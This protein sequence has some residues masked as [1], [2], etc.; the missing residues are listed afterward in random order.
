INMSNSG[1]AADTAPSIKT[2]VQSGVK[3]A[4]LVM[5]Q[6]FAP[7]IGGVET[8]LSDLVSELAK[9]RP[10]FV[11]TLKPIVTGSAS[12]LRRERRPNC[13]IRRFWW[14][15]GAVNIYRLLEPLPLLLFLYIVPYLFLR[16]FFFMLRH[17]RRISVIN[18]HG[19]NAACAAWPLGF[20]FRKKII[21]QT[22]SIYNFAPGSLFARAAAFIMNR[23]FK[24]LS[25][26][27]VGS[28]EIAAISV[29]AEKVGEFRYW[30]NLANFS[31]HEKAQA[32]RKAGWPAA[33]AV[34]FVG[35][36]LSI[37]GA[38]YAGLLARD[39][40]AL[41][42]YVIGDGPDRGELSEFNC[43]PNFSRLGSIPNEDL[44]DY[45]SAADL[46]I[47]P[48]QY[49]EGFG[50]VI[51]ESLACGTPVIASKL[52]G[53]PDALTE[54]AGILCNQDYASFRDAL[55]S[56]LAD[57]DWYRRLRLRAPIYAREKFSSRNAEDIFRHF[58]DTA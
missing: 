27:S 52:G 1:P 17:S 4:V 26:C 3:N 12:Y 2:G 10:V 46:L 49:A 50:R 33:R 18:A 47:V 32:K 16:T 34:L 56:I 55:K 29:S 7:D 57:D 13:D 22:H 31:V 39:F 24:V 11:C 5:S 8:H 21:M 44:P 38:R 19:I 36:L 42:F 40:P 54:E 20:L 43:L 37:K 6:S 58:R 41:R 53:I 14:F 28:R 35:R 15:G 51:C 30:I 23:S 25:L 9:T 45:Y 48:S